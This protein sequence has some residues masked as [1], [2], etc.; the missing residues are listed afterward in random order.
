LIK[1]PRLLDSVITHA[2]ERIIVIIADAGYGKTTLMAQMSQEMRGNSIWY[3]FDERDESA[4]VFL[5]HLTVGI[6]RVYPELG[7][8]LGALA[9]KAATIPEETDRWLSILVNGLSVEGG[10][11]ALFFFDDFHLVNRNEFIVG[12]LTFLFAHPPANCRFIIA[13]REKPSIC[14]GR[15]RA[16]KE[17]FDLETEDLAFNPE[18]S[19]LLLSRLGSPELSD[20]EILAWQRATEGWPIALAMSSS[21]IGGKYKRPEKLLPQL[22]KIAG[23]ISEYLTEEVWNSL[24]PEEQRIFAE[25][26]LLYEVDI[27][28]LDLAYAGSDELT[29]ANRFFRR[30]VERHLMISCLLGNRKYRFHA[31]FKEFL[32]GKLLDML[33]SQDIIDLHLKFAK[34]YEDAGQYENAIVHYFDAR[35]AEEAA[36]LIAERSDSFFQAGR[37]ETIKGWLRHI[38]RSVEE[39]MPMLYLLKA[40]ILKCEGRISEG[41]QELALAKS[42]LGPAGDK[43]SLFRI[44]MTRAGY[45]MAV[46]DY[47]AGLEAA[48]SAVSLAHTMVESIHAIN[49]QATFN[50]LLGKTEESIALWESALDLGRGEV[51]SLG[52]SIAVSMVSGKYF[53][54][55]FKQVLIDTGRLHKLDRPLE[56]LRERFVVLYMHVLALIETCQ[57]EQALIALDNTKRYIGEDPGEYY[58]LSLETLRG[59][60]KLYSG[61]GKAGRRL[62]K[63]V[64]ADTEERRLY[65]PECE[66]KIIGDHERRSNEVKDSIR[67]LTRSWSQL[68]GVRGRLLAKAATLASLG[69]SRMRLNGVDDEQAMADLDVAE[70]IAEDCGYRHIFTQVCFLRAWAD[71]ERGEVDRAVDGLR[72][73]LDTASSYLHNHFIVQEGR[74][75]LGLLARA[76]E[77]NI[78]RDYLKDI[79]TQ[80]GGEAVPALIPLMESDDTQTRID[81]LNAIAMAGGVT[82]APQIY[83]FLKD[84]DRDVRT[85]AK[86]VV[87]RLRSGIRDPQDVLTHRENEV[88]RRLSEGVSNAEIA[89]RLFIT[90]PTVK[91]H[92]TRIFQKLGVTK[93]TQAAAFFHQRMKETDN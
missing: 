21:L 13:S 32:L 71:M 30:A 78:H 43:E 87:S 74:L 53:L 46:E 18:E 77:K 20:K 49:R 85:N 80:I 61:E 25:S 83:H 54:G 28:V 66:L 19:G 47:P 12:A 11:P 34:A 68:S 92:I 63:K 26:S 82:V 35:Q 50:L 76:Y 51:G 91:T 72:R 48:E 6:S 62:L 93:R 41:L 38:P 57:Y 27:D 3:Q 90:E 79:F 29:P 58:H 59:M 24:D 45:L 31:L 8:E 64:V 4:M 2:D 16:Q 70:S 40:K 14:L 10:E 22:M 17:V 44:E 23:A 52:D 67:T 1:R 37:L 69:A 56:L 15:L 86:K 42:T 65:G 89:E 81:T 73:S 84:E 7:G 33:R 60:A 88:L 5:A 36:R 55:D 39:K 9:E 75:C